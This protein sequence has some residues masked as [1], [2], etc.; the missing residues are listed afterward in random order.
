[1]GKNFHVLIAKCFLD[2]GFAIMPRFRIVVMMTAILCAA[3]TLIALGGKPLQALSTVRADTGPVT[4]YIRA[5]GRVAGLHDVRLGVAMG[6]KVQAIHIAVGNKVEPGQELLQ[7]DDRDAKQ[8]L[9]I[10]ELAVSSI[11][12]SINHQVRTLYDLR[13]D[14][15]AGAVS[16]AQV[17]Q[18][19]ENL[20]LSRIQRQ[21]AEAQV[22]QTL[23]RI[24]Q[25]T[26]RSP[27]AGVVTDIAVR[28][29]ELAI[30]GQ[31]IVT[32]FDS[33][34]LQ[35][36]ANLEQDDVQD[37]R[38]N[39]PVQVLLDGTSGRVVQERVLRIEPAVRKEGSSSFTPVWISLTSPTLQLRPNQQVDVR[40]Q[41]GSQTPV[42]R[43]PLE[44]LSTDNGQ[45]AVWTLNKGTLHQLPI[46]TGAIGDRF[47]EVLS[48]VTPGQ[49]VV[50]AGGRLLKEG[51]HARE[52]RTSP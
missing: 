23:E 34:N 49:A 19:E 38:I 37:V 5:T 17:Q 43:L 18:A 39:M 25:L 48:G 2:K 27:I 3:L 52:V 6:G 33:G 21:K 26:L 44:A 35:I 50:L 31:P 11:D 47:V 32:V 41:I 22:N 42:L 13:A 24:K 20:A 10:D 29:G 45:T 14:L 40:V 9:A 51:E 1:M 30:A 7:L 46:Q 16:R 28:S 12:A 4:S 15:A 36:H 8:Q